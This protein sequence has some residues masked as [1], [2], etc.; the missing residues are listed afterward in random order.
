MTPQIVLRAGLGARL[1]ALAVWMF[2]PRE[3]LADGFRRLREAVPARSADQTATEPG[4]WAS[5]L[6]RPFVGPL[7]ALGLPGG[8]L[9]R[10]LSLLGR[11]ATVHLAEK[12]T[13]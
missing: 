1:W 11:S 10:D 9:E 8:R 3:S 13:L 12:A 6:G 7:A 5:V 2:P 4:G